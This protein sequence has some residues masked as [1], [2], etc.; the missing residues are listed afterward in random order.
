MRESAVKDRILDTASRLFYERGY[1]TTGIN[2][3]IEE[4][5]IARASLYNHFPSKTDLL[6]A[7]LNRTHAEWFV[8][9]DRYLASFN[10]P[11][12]KLLA[13]FDYRIGRQRMLK[14]K[15]CHF[16]KITAETSEDEQ[17]FLRV[18]THKE[19]FRQVIRDLVAQTRHRGVLDNDTL[20]DAL[21]LLL[22]GGIAVGAMFRSSEDAEKA[23]HIAEKLL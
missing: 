14:Y 13:L 22:E 7:Y 21:F 11:T 5:E 23:R 3:I 19:R 1:H 20:T 10:T 16:N 8:E 9:L 6:L 4:A 17:V 12:Q 2:Q 15:G 18:K